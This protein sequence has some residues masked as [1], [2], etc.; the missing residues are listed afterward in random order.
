MEDI[1]AVMVFESKFS[2][3]LQI[4]DCSGRVVGSCILQIAGYW[5]LFQVLDF[6]GRKTNRSK[7]RFMRYFREAH[8]IWAPTLQWAFRS[9]TICRTKDTAGAHP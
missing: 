9:T 4:A 7:A 5:P 1:L 6:A 2:R 8:W 3:R